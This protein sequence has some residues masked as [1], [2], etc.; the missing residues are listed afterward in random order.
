ML[1]LQETINHNKE[2]NDGSCVAFLDSSKAF[3]TVWHTGLLY[4]LSEIE[5]PPKIWL[6]LYVFE[7]MCFCK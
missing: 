6:I 5:I 3:D 2:R 4:K 7:I 1:L